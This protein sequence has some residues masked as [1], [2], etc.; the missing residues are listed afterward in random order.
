M[1]DLNRRM[2]TVENMQQAK[3]TLRRFGMRRKTLIEWRFMS[4]SHTFLPPL[5]RS[6][7]GAAQ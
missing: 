1:P 7:S 3:A 6:T 5:S 2:T 4:K